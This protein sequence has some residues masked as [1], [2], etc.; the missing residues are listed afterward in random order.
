MF[1]PF[2]AVA[3]LGQSSNLSWTG[4]LWPATFTAHQASS[5]DRA[6]KDEKTDWFANAD[7]GQYVRTETVDG[8]TENVMADIR[9]SGRIVR[10]WSAN[11]AGTLRFY[12]DGAQTPFVEAPFADFVA[13]KPDLTKGK[14]YESAKGF[15]WYGLMEFGTSMKVTLEGKDSN[16]VYYH[17]GYE[18]GE[19]QLENA[20]YEDRPVGQASG[21]GRV[22]VRGV[23][24]IVQN[25]EIRANLPTSDVS[26][27]R[28]TKVQIKTEDQVRLEVP[29]GDLFATMVEAKPYST[30]VTRVAVE[31]GQNGGQTVVLTLR[32]PMPF[33][34]QFSCLLLGQ[35][36]TGIQAGIKVEYAM[37]GSLPVPP[38]RLYGEWHH[39]RGMSRPFADLQFL[40]AQGPGR[41]VGTVMT[42]ENPTG[43][44]WGEGDEKVFVDR[45]AQPS[46]F[47]TGTEDYFG[48]A[49]CWP[50]PFARPFHAQPVVDGPGNFGNTAVLRWHLHDSIPFTKEIDFRI[51]RWHWEDV[52]FSA[53]MTALWY[54][55]PDSHKVRSDAPVPLRRLLAAAP[56][57]GAI[58]GEGLKVLE[59]SGGKTSEQGGF[60]NLSRGAQL[61]WVDPV[62][63]D[64]LRLQVPIDRPGRFK[65]SMNLCHAKDY[66]RHA[67]SLAGTDLGTVDFYSPSLKWQI[68]ELG[69]VELKAGTA[70]LVVRCQG[71][72]DE[73]EPRR[74]FGLDYIVLQRIGDEMA[75]AGVR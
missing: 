56:V 75:K 48:Y 50:E 31:P 11:P 38:F 26:R 67:M 53:G 62:A 21:Q 73:A 16:R 36:G 4:L 7:Y 57:E 46:F 63:G 41:Y 6:S 44:W 35:G 59:V 15:N 5:Y 39:Q 8:R 12:R 14:A 13:G 69:T 47:G 49:W 33:Q 23:N 25:L 55:L 54:A 32:L 24:G 1:T 17:V 29:L 34:K 71:S 40:K 60:Y 10:V 43:T 52:D 22:E 19:R 61:W 45:E 37:L 9:G 3:V 2:V 70:E 68:H 20:S 28:M 58:E 30:A 72:V 18:L 66:G 64:V 74:M 42:V 27:L 65:V 51:E